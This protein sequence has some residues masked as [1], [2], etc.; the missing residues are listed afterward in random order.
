MMPRVPR[1]LFVW[2]L[3]LVQRTTPL[4]RPRVVPAPGR[5]RSPVPCPLRGKTGPDRGLINSYSYPHPHFPF[6]TPHAP[7]RSNTQ[8]ARPPPTPNLE[9]SASA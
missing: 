8:H 9:P 4:A 5:R 3:G 7:G 6:L 1:C 2:G